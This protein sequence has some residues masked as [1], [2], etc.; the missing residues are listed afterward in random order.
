MLAADAV[1]KSNSGHPGMPMGAADMAFVLLTRHLRFDPREPRWLGRDRFVLS[2]GHGS[3]LLYSLLH[4]AGFDCTLDDLQSFRQLHSRTPGHPEFGLLPGV[5]VTSGPLG[6]GFGNGVGI[7]RASTRPSRRRRRT[8]RA[9]A[10]S[11]SGPPS[12]SERPARRESRPS[13]ARR[14]ARRS[15]PPPGR[16]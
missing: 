6:Q 13:T 12:A 14:S 15:S 2:A 4:L 9:R 8:S 16:R 10:S 11:A 3:M 5:E 7:A 1:Q